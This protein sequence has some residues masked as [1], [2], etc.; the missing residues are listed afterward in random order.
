MR[1]R[2]LPLPLLS[3]LVTRTGPT[4]LVL[5]TW[6][7]P[8][9]CLSMVPISITRIGSTPSG[10]RLTLVRIRSVSAKAAARA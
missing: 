4:S 3:V 10:M 2:L 1:I 6:V 9:A 5:A 7:P 8:S